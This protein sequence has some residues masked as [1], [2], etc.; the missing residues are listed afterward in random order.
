MNPMKAVRSISIGWPAL[1]YKAITKWKKLDFLKLLGGCFSKWAR[2]MPMLKSERNIKFIEM[3]VRKNKNVPMDETRVF[4]SWKPVT[5]V[6]DQF[7]TFK[8]D[9]PTHGCRHSMHL[10]SRQ[11]NV[12]S[13]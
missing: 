5:H 11:E 4:S 13:A 7:H 3:Y 2:P 6:I 1:S 8:K 9:F 10:I 12:I